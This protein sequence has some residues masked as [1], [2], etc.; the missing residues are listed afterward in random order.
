[1]KI[2]FKKIFGADFERG[3]IS[4]RFLICICGTAL[5]VVFGT[6]DQLFPSADALKT[7]L[8]AG[9]H[10]SMVNK[11][12]KSEAAV[13]IIPIL[14]T[15]PLSGIFLE[16]HKSRFEKLFI[17][18]C[19]RK[20]YVFSKV[21]ATALCGGL[22]IL[23]GLLLITGVLTL[24]YRPMEIGNAKETTKLL[25][26][27]LQ[28]AITAALMGVLWASLGAFLGVINMN[29]YMAYGGPFITSYLLIILSTRYFQQIYVLNPRE[30]MLR[31]HYPAGNPWGIIALLLEV[32]IIIMLMEGIAIWKKVD[33]G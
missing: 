26:T 22:G 25:L 7:G 15:L 29:S 23:F 9:Y 12:L 24:I 30:W 31:E 32:C 13:F 5:M 27:L 8:A 1:M 21:L 17:T 20:S 3:L 4:Y 2:K 6:W 10:L 19:S 16:E 11:S 18:R 14:S 28:Y 33:L